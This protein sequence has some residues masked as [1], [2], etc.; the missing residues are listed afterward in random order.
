[1]KID[2]IHIDGFG[3]FHE[4]EITGFHTGVNVLYGKNEAGKSTLLDFIRFT[5]FGYPRMTIQRRQPLYGGNHGG[6]IWLSTAENDTVMVHRKGNNNLLVE[7]NGQSSD[8]ERNYL[9]LMGNATSE[10]YQNVYAIT[11]DELFEVQQLSDSGMEDRIFSMGMGLSGIDFGSFEK[12]LIEHANRYFTPKGRNQILSETV[13]KIEEKELKITEL[14]QKLGEYNRLSEELKQFEKQREELLDKRQVLLRKS[15]DL[16][17]LERAYSYF[18]TY[19]E[20]EKVS[21]T[22]APFSPRPKQLLEDFRQ[23]KV[24]QTQIDNELKRLKEEVD[25]FTKEIEQLNLNHHLVDKLH[26]LDYLKSTIKIYEESTLAIHNEEQKLARTIQQVKRINSQLGE[27]FN[28]SD[29]V[30]LEGTFDLRNKAIETSEKMDALARISERKSDEINQ[31][32]RSLEE[33]QKQLNELDTELD[34]L[35]LTSENAVQKKKGELV[36]VDT[37]FQQALKGTVRQTVGKPLVYAGIVGGLF[38]CLLSYFLWEYNFLLSS[39]SGLTGISL[40]VMTY[41]YSPKNSVSERNE[42]DAHELNTKLNQLQQILMQ[43]DRIM[44]KKQALLSEQST[45]LSQLQHAELDYAQQTENYENVLLLWQNTLTSHQIPSSVTPRSMGDF[46]SQVEELKRLHH[47]Q[48][49]SIQQLER[50]KGLKNEFETKLTEID[51]TQS[52]YSTEWIYH[53]IRELESNEKKWTHHQLL[54]EKIQHHH[55]KLKTKEVELEQIQNELTK[56]LEDVGVHTEA[57]FYT[58]FEQQEQATLVTEKLQEATNAIRVICGQDNFE[59]TIA[60]LSEIQHTSELST[61][62]QYAKESYEEV[63]NDYE[64]IGKKIATHKAHIHH[65]LQPDEMTKLLTEQQSLETALH[66]DAKEWFS[67]KMALKVLN[68]S[69]QQFEE[70]KQPEVITYTR[71]YFREITNG[72]YSDL[73]ISLSDKHVSIIDHSGRAKMVEE[74]SRGTREQLLLALRMGLIEE[75]EKNSVPLPVVL[76]D[77]MVNFDIHRAQNLARSLTAFGANRQVILFTCHEHT[78]DLFASTNATI[79]NW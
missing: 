31:L 34:T 17:N 65:I 72:A 3:A 32:K 66:E 64:E 70:D 18:V 24:Q 36:S 77:V 37:Q 46:L 20:A 9:R 22:L 52:D 59:S 13:R 61:Q 49:E 62:I 2:K 21:T 11:L 56:L 67:T 15:T 48:L 50:L 78:R 44:L 75:Y 43:Y 74:L 76:D 4:K 57:N 79:I 69:K 10:L 42:Y 71:N 27:S 55:Q 60:S 73:R 38:M 6:R 33:L 39:I 19:K 23:L 5:L 8:Q 40:L 1:M 26:I 68:E 28:T 30:D 41:L 58:F 51:A 14:K 12:G 47:D 7:H 29:V 53:T 54:T 25:Y 35:G 45:L 63:N 16:E